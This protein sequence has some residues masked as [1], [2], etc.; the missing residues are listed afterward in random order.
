MVG[1]A[2]P[3]IVQ[4]VWTQWIIAE[5]WIHLANINFAWNVIQNWKILDVH[6]VVLIFLWASWARIYIMKEN[7]PLIIGY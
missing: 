2:S 5:S 4:Y 1:E 6:C 3:G 7:A